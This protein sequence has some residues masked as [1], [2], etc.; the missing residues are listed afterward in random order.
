MAKRQRATFIWSSQL[1]ATNVRWSAATSTVQ[2]R[3]NRIHTHIHMHDCV[4][5]AVWVVRY[6][7]LSNSALCMAN[8]PLLF[9]RVWDSLRLWRAF[10]RSLCVCDFKEYLKCLLLSK[11]TI[12][13]KKN[14][15]LA[16]KK[17]LLKCAH[18]TCYECGIRI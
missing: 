4:L 2:L 12:K 17:N 1:R 9:S 10:S 15:K 11:K 13:A 8:W 5:L 18:K 7:W 6:A 16:K 14:K 3:T